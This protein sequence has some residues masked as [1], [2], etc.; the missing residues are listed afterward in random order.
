VGKQTE[1]QSQ[2]SEVTFYCR[3]NTH[4]IDVYP[5]HPTLPMHPPLLISFLL[6]IRTYYCSQKTLP[7]EVFSGDSVQNCSEW[8][9]SRTCTNGSDKI[10]LL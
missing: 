1:T 2:S 9:K 3:A 5:V 7:H 10:A 6:S 8:E 4:T